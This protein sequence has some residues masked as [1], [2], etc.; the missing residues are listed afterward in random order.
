METLKEHAYRAKKILSNKETGYSI[1]KNNIISIFKYTNNIKGYSK[2]SIII[3]LTIL[4]SYYSTQMNKRYYGI[5]DLANSIWSIANT[6]EDFNYNILSF[7]NNPLDNDK[8]YNLFNTNYGIHK[9]GE[10][11]GKAI[12]LISK[13]AYYQTEYR[14]PIYD[15][16]VK[17][18][19]PLII[20]KYYKYDNDF[21]VVNNFKGDNSPMNEY[22]NF[23]NNIKMLN[24]KSDINNFDILDNLLWLSGKFSKNNYSLVLNK[25]DY[26][27]TI[28]DKYDAKSKQIIIEDIDSLELSKDIKEI[29]RFVRYIKS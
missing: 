4:D 28:K 12:S 19:F 27:N 18:V 11:A 17:K 26:F 5:E 16:L 23:N 24:E 20:E 1:N 10:D 2:D 25:D 21:P 7:L 9:N 29:M 13:Y 14:Y 15:S 22:I 8:I 6:K 3:Q